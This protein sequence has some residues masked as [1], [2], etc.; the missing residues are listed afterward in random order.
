MYHD[1]WEIWLISHIHT[2]RTTSVVIRVYFIFLV[3]LHI[4]GEKIGFYV[5]NE[6][7]SVL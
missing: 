2:V 6:K 1:Y 4:I 5:T 3:I 7:L